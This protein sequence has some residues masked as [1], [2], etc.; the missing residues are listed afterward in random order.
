MSS[1]FEL[2]K[3]KLTIGFWITTGAKI[4]LWAGAITANLFILLVTVQDNI[5]TGSVDF[6][7]IVLP[8]IVLGQLFGTVPAILVGL[9]CGMFMGFV[10]YHLDKIDWLTSGGSEGFI[11]T[12]G[13]ILLLLFACSWLEP[14]LIVELRRSFYSLQIFEV[15]FL[16]AAAGV[17]SG[18]QLVHHKRIRNV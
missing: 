6:Y 3:P 9:V 15:L 18:K 12:I 17:W 8:Y 13:L 4:G 5:S 11:T 7:D 1:Y 10:F 2:Q 16:F 14:D